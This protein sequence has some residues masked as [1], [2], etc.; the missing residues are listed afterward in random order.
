MANKINAI[1]LLEVVID[2]FHEIYGEN[3]TFDK[4]PVIMLL[5]NCTVIITNYDGEIRFDVI[6]DKPLE[7]DAT[8]DLYCDEK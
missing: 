1:Q 7:I 3:E 8:L 2:K 4:T 6:P 5:N